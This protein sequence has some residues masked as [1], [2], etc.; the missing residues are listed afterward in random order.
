MNQTSITNSYIQSNTCPYDVHRAV[1]RNIFLWQKQ[2]D[3]PVFQ[4]Y[5]ILE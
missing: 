5:F 1:H 3:A 2:L 4:I